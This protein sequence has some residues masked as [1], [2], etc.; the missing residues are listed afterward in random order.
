MIDDSNS[1]VWLQHSH[2]L[3]RQRHM[4]SRWDTW[5]AKGE[6]HL[7]C[8]GLKQSMYVSKG[9]HPML[10][11]VPTQAEPYTHRQAALQY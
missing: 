6:K 7:G 9:R 5:C 1:K 3:Q 10:A 2:M 4:C 11:H 8:Q